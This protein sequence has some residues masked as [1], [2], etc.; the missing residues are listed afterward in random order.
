MRLLRL[1]NG[2]LQLEL[3][4]DQLAAFSNGLNE[5]L[6]AVEDWE[7]R[8]RLGVDRDAARGWLSELRVLERQVEQ[9]GD[10]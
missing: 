2:L 8:T 3:T 5:A 6:N 7:F 9:C 1:D 4:G 10:A